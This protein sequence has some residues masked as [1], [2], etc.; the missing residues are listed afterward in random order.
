MGR[1]AARTR[2]L[3]LAASAGPLAWAV[4]FGGNS[5]ITALPA[6]A[7]AAAGVAL[8]LASAVCL[9]R[10]PVARLD[11]SGR[12]G[13][14]AGVALVLLIGLS[15]VWS[16]APDRSYGG[17]GQALQYAAFAAVGFFV[18]GAL[19]GRAV[20]SLAGLLVGLLL[21][22]LLVALVIRIFP[23]LFPDA[24]RIA[25]LREPVGYW[26][27]LSLLAGAGA[28]LAVWLLGTDSRPARV[29]GVALAQWGVV[30]VVLTQSRAGLAGL[31]AVVALALAAGHSRVLD[32]SRLLAAS[33]P[34]VAVAGWAFSRPALMEAGASRGDRA[35]DGTILAVLLVVAL[36]V[37]AA[38]VA[39]GR[40]ERVVSARRGV[41]LPSL[42]ALA[43]AAAIGLAASAAASGLSLGECS[44]EAGR[45][46]EPCLNNRLDWWGETLEIF[47]DNP[48]GT[49]AR[50]YAIARFQVRDD[51][52][53]VTEPHSVPLQL[54]AD[55]GLAGVLLGIA[56]AVAVVLGARRALAAVG[57]EER[58][59][60]V[61]L[62]GVPLA[63]GVHSLVDYDLDFLAVTAPALFVCGALFALGRPLRRS[64][65]GLLG[66][67]AAA[68][69]AALLAVVVL[70]PWLAE[71]RLEAAEASYDAGRLD[72][73]LEQVRAA[74]SLDPLA[75]E[76]VL[77][78]A[79]F[80]QLDGDVV[81]ARRL[82][83]LAVSRQ[84]ENP[85]THRELGLFE[86]DLGRL[87][88]AYQALNDA[89]TLDPRATSWRD[90]GE[91]DRSRDA[92]NEGACEREAPA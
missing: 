52:T 82:Y 59:A 60:L 65:A 74:R 23:A 8:L 12:L 63:Y 61:G 62:L 69:G 68:A 9:G 37:G 77:S 18:A 49:G 40:V 91:L 72:R 87:C 14:V 89:Y 90:G 13:V 71:R 54:L 44:N 19:G 83:R 7:L 57:L 84:P 20:R 2:A 56:V 53:P 75:L 15:V 26:N 16:L 45:G 25:R 5:R 1:P 32:A 36:L 51:G 38:T 70:G 24:V 33:A 73:A 58:P 31:L 47:R 43:A 30:V 50:T 78:E 4:F 55:L 21:V 76:P 48:Q 92:V 17:L 81:G 86:F 67:A 35:R 28:A 79:L 39:R 88:A 3:L 41:V 29:A 11:G 10:L 22:L 66:V 85:R 80:T 42:L 27:A 34:G 64:Q 46:F 6:P